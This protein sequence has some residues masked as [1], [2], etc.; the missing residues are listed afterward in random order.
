MVKAVAQPCFYVKK[1]S[2]EISKTLSHPRILGSNE[3]LNPEDTLRITCKIEKIRKAI[4][5]RHYG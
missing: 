5:M 4:D 3:S 2:K 1:V